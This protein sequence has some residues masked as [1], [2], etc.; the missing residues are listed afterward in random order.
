MVHVI[1]QT[2]AV[3]GLPS[4]GFPTDASVFAF[5]PVADGIV[6]AGTDLDPSWIYASF[7]NGGFFSP[8]S[9]GLAERASVEAFAVNETYMFAGTDD[10]GVWRRLKP[11]VVNA[12]TANRIFHRNL[13]LRKT[14]QIHLIQLQQFRYSI[15][16]NSFV[17]LKIYDVLGNEVATLAMKKELQEVMKLNLMQPDL[18]VEYISTNY[19]RAILSKQK[20]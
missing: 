11:G 16:E 3:P 10:H 19:N 6:L 15:K 9:E 1:L 2:M 5:G 13:V 7:D 17:S 14:I 4:N 20:K 18:R 12:Q 8:Y